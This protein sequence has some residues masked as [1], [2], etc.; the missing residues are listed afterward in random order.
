ME[1]VRSSDNAIRKPA[2]PFWFF[3]GFFVFLLLVSLI[4]LSDAEKALGARWFLKIHLV[5]LWLL[6][7]LS[8]ALLSK[9]CRRGKF[10]PDNA[11]L[12]MIFLAMIA[13]SAFELLG[14]AV[15][16]K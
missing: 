3:E 6:I 12:L 2:I 15:S 8:G 1:E 5:A 11:G 7:A 10:D 9:L 4:G 13:S 16:F 14:R